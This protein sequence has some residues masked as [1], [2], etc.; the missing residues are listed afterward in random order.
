MKILI[1]GGV[2]GGATAAARLRRLHE[3]WQIVMFERGDYVSFANCGLPYYVGGV[4]EEEDDLLLQTPESF[5]SRFHIDVRVRNEVTAI[6]TAAKR[7]TVKNLLTGEAYQETYDKLLLSP[8]SRPIAPFQGEN[9][10]TVTTVNDAARIKAFCSAGVRRAVVIGGGFIGLE[11]AENL[12]A[13]GIA[14]SVVEKADHVMPNLDGEMAHIIHKHMRG[15]GMEILTG[16]GVKA[17][18]GN[19]VTLEDGRV[20]EAEAVICAIGVRP[21]AQLAKESGIRCSE[22]GA[23][24]VNAQM[25]T[26]APD[27]FAVGDAVEIVNRVTGQAARIPLA[28]PANKQARLA[29][30]VMAGLG[31]AYPGSVGVSILKLGELTAASVGA[32]ESVLKVLGLPYT[33]SYTH[34]FPHATYYP[35]GRQMTIKLL[36]RPDGGAV[37]GA[38]IVG[39]EGVDKRIDT[40]SV[41]IQAGLSVEALSNLELA[42]A[43]PYSSAKDPVNMAGYVAD[44]I[45]KGL[46]QVFYVSDIPSLDPEKDLLVDIRTPSEFDQGTIPGA[47]NL[48]LDDIRARFTELPKDKNLYIFCRIGL[49][50]YLGYRQLVQLGF[51]HVRNLSGGY[52]SYLEVKD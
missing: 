1:I 20:L 30:D 47:V 33:K 40:I 22:R 6:D 37:W 31:G 52:L 36:F 51:E 16:T 10:F 26:S 39:Y 43:P 32:S 25:R 28:G 45:A 44:N 2:A 8:G 29:A 35:G 11:M 23:I 19:E 15:M 12:H 5:Y 9:V 38:Q 48:P 27:V 18:E 3:D 7:V 41:A 14:V 17:V 4:I 24:E 50:G 49:R 21:E 46:H 13:M 34:S 42:Y